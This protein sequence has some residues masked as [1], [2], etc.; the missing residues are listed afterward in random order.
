MKRTW[1]RLGLAL[2]LCAVLTGCGVQRKLPPSP[3]P[4]A[5]VVPTPNITA[6][7]IVKEE[8]GALSFE[9]PGDWLKSK[10]E[11]ATYFHSPDAKEMLIF[12]TMKSGVQVNKDNVD[13]LLKGLT[14]SFQNFREID[15]RL[16]EIDDRKTLEVRYFK[17]SDRGNA[18]CF[19]ELIQTGADLTLFIYEKYPGSGC[20]WKYFDS[21]L[22]SIDVQSNQ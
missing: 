13:I 5:S 15:H 21:I 20:E 22:K 17:E 8:Y 7:P 19:A 11:K 4:T 16:H 18:E 10:R 6:V 2:L 1:G 12:R 14:Q 3:S 9:V